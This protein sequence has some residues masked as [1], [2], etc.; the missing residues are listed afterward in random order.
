MK[1][2]EVFVFEAASLSH[3]T[4]QTFLGL[5]PVMAVFAR[6][7]FGGT[8]HDSARPKKGLGSREKARAYFL[9]LETKIITF[10]FL[11]Y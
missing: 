8:S 9:I 10:I 4:L 1:V 6:K 7:A 2:L 5:A 3:M 11:R